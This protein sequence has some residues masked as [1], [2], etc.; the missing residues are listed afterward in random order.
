V[1]FLFRFT[2]NYAIRKTMPYVELGPVVH[3]N[4]G[5]YWQD[6]YPEKQRVLPNYSVGVVLGVGMEQ[7]FNASRAFSIGARVSWMSSVDS[8]VKIYSNL[9]FELV[10]GF[11][12]F[13][14]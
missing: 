13:K 8:R 7:Y 6:K 9:S 2:N 12:L 10:A 11:S 3:A 4:F 14:M 1:P 5:N